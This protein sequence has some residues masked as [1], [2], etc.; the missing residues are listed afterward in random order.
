M[1]YVGRV[2]RPSSLLSFPIS[3]EMKLYGLS[4]LLQRAGLQNFIFICDLSVWV[5]VVSCGVFFVWLLIFVC[6]V[7]WFCCF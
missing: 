2:K 4:T 7:G 1:A 6:L 5:F 3:G